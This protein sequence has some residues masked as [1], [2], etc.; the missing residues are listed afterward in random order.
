MRIP[1]PAATQWEL[2]R[3]ALPQLV[4]AWDE[5]LRQA[6]QGE[7]VYNDDTTMKVLAL[8]ASSGARPPPT[9][10]PTRGRACSP[11]GSSP[12][13]TATASPCSSPAASTRARIAD[14]LAQRAADLAPPIQMCDA[15]ATNTAGDFDTLL[16][17]CLAHARRR[18]VDVVDNFPAEVRHV[19]E[20]REVYRTDALA[21]ERA[22][23][24]RSAC[25]ST[26]PSGR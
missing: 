16:A 24:P 14:V 3:D 1:L 5:L 8:T 7:V 15:L 4:P 11:R 13:A 22:C 17:S 2:V 6:A 25:A 18:F 23:P 12:P 10:R 20:T 9:R 21:R 26:R 19:L